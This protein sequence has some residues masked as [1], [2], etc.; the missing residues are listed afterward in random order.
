[1]DDDLEYIGLMAQ[2]WDPLRGDTSEW[3]D[4][5]FFLALIRSVGEPVLDVGCGTGRLLVDY[6][7]QGIDIDGVEISP[8][9]VAILCDK[10][11]AAGLDIDG[12]VHL[13]AMETMNLPRRYQ[14]V[15]VPSGSYHLLVD[16]TQAATAMR[17][18][19]EHV[20][21]GGTLAVTWLDIAQDH[22]D[23]AD[24]RFVKEAQLADGSTIRRTYRAR[25]DSATGLEHTDDLYERLRDGVIVE[26]QRRLRSPA[27]RH[28]PRH[29]I[30]GIHEDAGF[31]NVRLMSMTTGGPAEPSERAIM[32]V[33]RRPR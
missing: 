30:A 16:T 17:R 9:M 18:F 7:A 20:R 5:A 31:E 1:V 3:A 6:L 10:A 11:A 13:G 28:Y 4:R 33:A 26:H 22:P 21:P 8:D 23:G 27:T 14:L 32:S 19:F 12:R 24:E 2:G 29:A 15:I 25:F